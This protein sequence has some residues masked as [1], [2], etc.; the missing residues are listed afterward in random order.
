MP[1]NE[2][3][4]YSWQSSV[5]CTIFLLGQHF[6]QKPDKHKGECKCECGETID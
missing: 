2:K 4:G 6:C 1:K 5:K 3:C